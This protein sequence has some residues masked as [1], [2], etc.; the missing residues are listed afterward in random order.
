MSLPLDGQE[1]LKFLDSY[2]E[3]QVEFFENMLKKEKMRPMNKVGDEIKLKYLE[4]KCKLEPDM[5][6]HILEI[7]NFPLNRA[8]EICQKFNNYFG[9]AFIKFRIGVK[10]EAI[11]EYLKVK[12][13]IS[14]KKN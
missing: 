13:S 11:D 10:E 4:L 1:V 12:A 7:Y 14:F 2:P 8:L 6:T 9:T 3:L 5:V